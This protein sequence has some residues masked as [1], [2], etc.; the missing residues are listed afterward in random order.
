MSPS[1]ALVSQRE[2]LDTTGVLHL[3]EIMGGGLPRGSLL[4]VMGLPGSGKTTLASQIA[5]TAAQGGMRVLVL[6]ALSESTGKLIEHLRAFTFFNQ[7]LIG[8]PVQ[9]LSLQGVLAQ[10]LQATSK[11][12]LDE[13]RRVRADI[14]L[15]DGFRGM[16]SVD[17]EPQAAREFLYELGTALSTLQTTT[18]V[19]S[20]TDPRD[21][22][23]FPETTI[24]DF[25]LGLHY[26]LL[27]VRQV[28]AIEVVKARTSSPMPGLHAM[29]LSQDGAS[30]YPQLEERIALELLGGE[31]AIQ[32]GSRV[33]PEVAIPD[34]SVSRATFDL[35]ELD[36]MLAGGLPRATCTLLAGSLGTGKTLLALY[37]ALAGIRAGERVVFLGF[38][39]SRAQLALAAKSFDIGPDIAR[40]LQSEEDLV[41]LEM[42]PIKVNPDILG[43]R[44]LAELDRTGAQRL[45]VDS[46]AELERGVVRSGDPQRLEDYLAAL[47]LAVRSRQVTALM[48]KETDKALAATL[49][50]SSDALSVLAENVM[51][52]QQ[53]PF[54]GELHRILSIIKL[55]FSEHDPSVRE[56]RIRAPDGL[57]M[58][59]RLESGPGVLEGIADDQEFATTRRPRPARKSTSQGAS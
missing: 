28:R 24:A 1:D 48:L 59:R 13:A 6:T 33:T 23:F 47:L 57:Q 45:I 5:F 9:F 35:P 3:D 34:P 20:E 14:I 53:V 26:T 7:D 22:T 8:G 31:A 37:Y 2:R 21:P 39:E 46:I 18:I 17:T 58:L 10:G 29:V 32:G 4:L 12:I 16:R 25:I 51:L 41:F 55:R 43:D 44:L 11:V 36:A 15:L 56:F 50:F 49:D 38:R 19:T 27:G 42:P 52:M 40:A 54:G 30:V